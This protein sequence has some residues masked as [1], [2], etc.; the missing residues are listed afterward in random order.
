MNINRSYFNHAEIVGD[1]TLK[2]VTQYMYTYI[3][4]SYYRLRWRFALV[5]IE[6]KYYK[7]MQRLLNI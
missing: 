7:T 2:S 3:E 5:S 1:S 4:V 6:L